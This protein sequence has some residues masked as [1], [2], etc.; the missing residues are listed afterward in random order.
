MKA[1]SWQARRWHQHKGGGKA[2]AAP[3]LMYSPLKSS[4]EWF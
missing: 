3:L 4:V 2:I 1:E